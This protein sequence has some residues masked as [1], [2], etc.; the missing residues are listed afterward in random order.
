MKLSILCI[1]VLQKP[2]QSA[3]HFHLQYPFLPGGTHYTI[4]WRT[5][6]SMKKASLVCQLIYSNKIFDKISL[7][8]NAYL[9]ILVTFC[10]I[11]GHLYEFYAFILPS[12]S[13]KF[14]P[15]LQFH[16]IYCQGPKSPQCHVKPRAVSPYPAEAIAG[17]HPAPHTQP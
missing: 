8:I 3:L 1:S 4:D 5:K 17:L 11:C 16:S 10:L 7:L 15:Q 9:I 14:S 12:Y 13:Q 6:F 2:S